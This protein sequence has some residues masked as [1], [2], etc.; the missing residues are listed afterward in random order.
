MGDEGPQQVVLVH[1]HEGRGARDGLWQV[2]G[3]VRYSA[4]Q[5]HNSINFFLRTLFYK[6]T[7]YEKL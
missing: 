1:V 3:N 7:L 5:T 2:A 4:Q 6:K